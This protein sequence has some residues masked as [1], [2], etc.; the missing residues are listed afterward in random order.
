MSSRGDRTQSP[1]V[2]ITIVVLAVGV[3]VPVGIGTWIGGILLTENLGVRMSPEQVFAWIIAALV[4][5]VLWPLSLRGARRAF[6]NATGT[7]PGN[8]AASRGE[9]TLRALVVTVGAVAL[10]AL[11]G[12]RETASTLATVWEALAIGRRES[13]L[14]IQ[15]LSLVLVA[16][17]AAPVVFFTHRAAKMLSPGDPRRRVLQ[18]REAWTLA[19]ATAWTVSLMLGLSLAIAI[20]LWL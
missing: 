13:G 19:A 3:G 2:Q 20:L 10:V 7:G 8:A 9:R 14:L 17:L 15:F 4:G 18:E 1:A 12:P 5:V 16:I 6:S 11:C